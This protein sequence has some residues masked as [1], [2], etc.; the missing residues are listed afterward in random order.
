M[1][2]DP[3]IKLEKNVET[4]ETLAFRSG[5]AAPGRDRKKLASKFGADACCRIPRIPYRET[6][7]K[8]VKVPGS[9]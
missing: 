8:T 5:R 4:T 2:E 7:R 1:E 6:I 3:T 9:S